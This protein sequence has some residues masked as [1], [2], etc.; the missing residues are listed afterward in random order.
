MASP[1]RSRGTPRAT[2]TERWDN[3]PRTTLS[4]ARGREAVADAVVVEDV[5]GVGGGVA[6]VS[7]VV[8]VR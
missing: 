6:E 1:V 2:G 7:A 8:N 5:G 3:G 4:P